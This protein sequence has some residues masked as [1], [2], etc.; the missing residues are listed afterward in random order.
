MEYSVKV[1][2]IPPDIHIPENLRKKIRFDSA[3]KQIVFRGFMCKTDYDQLMRLSDDV[4]FQSGVSQL[5]QISTVSDAPPM[6]RYR[7]I[8]AAM[9]IACFLFVATAWWLL[10]SDKSPEAIPASTVNTSIEHRN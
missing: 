2:S 5:F 1:Y 7:Q 8:L 3:Q 4:S 6:R 9:T 10:L